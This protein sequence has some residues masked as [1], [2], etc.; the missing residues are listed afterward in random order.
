MIATNASPVR[1]V[2]SW[3]PVPAAM[4]RWQESS[5]G[6]RHV[7][8]TISEHPAK[9]VRSCGQVLWATALNDSQV[10]LAWGWA[11]L[12]GE[13]VVMTDPM[14]VATNLALVDD[15]SG[16]PLTASQVMC[17]LNSVIYGL[18]WQETIRNAMDVRPQ[19]PNLS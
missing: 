10:G 4:R 8:T 6:L 11:C 19:A 1:S 14:G 13:V 9:G 12:H 18:P 15:E 5:A 7:G 2:K 16:E 3:A 17:C